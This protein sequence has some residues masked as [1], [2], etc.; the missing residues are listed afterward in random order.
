M[1]VNIEFELDDEIWGEYKEGIN[2]E[3]FIEDL[4][5]NWHGKDRVEKVTLKSIDNEE[6]LNVNRAALVTLTE[7]GAKVVNDHIKNNEAIRFLSE[8][9]IKTL[10]G[11]NKF[12]HGDTYKSALWDIMNI[13]GKSMYVGCDVPF[14]KN[15]INL[16]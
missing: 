11:Q 4:F 16:L 9:Q 7:S 10:F 15:E 3:L 8:D 5:S 12:K 13:F 2:P 14:I 1:K 6:P